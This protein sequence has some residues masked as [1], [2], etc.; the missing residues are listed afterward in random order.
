MLKIGK[1]EPICR[2]YKSSLYYFFNISES[3][4]LFQKKT[5]ERNKE[6]KLKWLQ[7]LHK[8]SIIRDISWGQVGL[9]DGEN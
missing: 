9:N 7:K 3:L 8:I 4:K 6:Q 5:V 2:T 1:S